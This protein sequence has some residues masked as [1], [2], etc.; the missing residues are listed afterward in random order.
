MPTTDIG[1]DPFPPIQR[2]R[3]FLRYSGACGAFQVSSLE[4]PA[5]M[6]SVWGRGSPLWTPYFIENRSSRSQSSPSVCLSSHQ[7]SVTG[8]ALEEFWFINQTPVAVSDMNVKL[9]CTTVEI[10]ISLFVHCTRLLRAWCQHGGTGNA[11]S[12][13][14]CLWNKRQ[15]YI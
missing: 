2:N 11:A 6:V 10:Y 15:K 8:L 5:I 4:V 7:W 13:Q 9:K 12:D 3:V 14:N 1:G